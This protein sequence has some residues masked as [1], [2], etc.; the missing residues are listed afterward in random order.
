M[1]M[2]MW[3]VINMCSGSIINSS[4]SNLAASNVAW[5]FELDE[6]EFRDNPK[7]KDALKHKTRVDGYGGL[8]VAVLEF[9]ATKRIPAGA[10]V[11]CGKNRWTKHKR[12]Y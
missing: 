2:Y 7:R 9:Y 12:R 1:L 3:V 5:R 11:C 8:E 10:V 6:T 4:H